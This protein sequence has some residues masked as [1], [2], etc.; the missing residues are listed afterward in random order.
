MK[1]IQY[2]HI[3]EFD[4]Y[5]ERVGA[6]GGIHVAVSQDG[7]CAQT[8]CAART[9]AGH[10]HNDIR[11]PNFGLV[12][13]RINRVRNDDGTL[14]STMWHELAHLLAPNTWHT[15]RWKAV[16]VE[17]GQPLGQFPRPRRKPNHYYRVYCWDLVEKCGRGDYLVC[18]QAGTVA[19]YCE[20]INGGR[21]FFYVEREWG[22]SRWERAA[23]RRV[24][25]VF[26]SVLDNQH[27]CS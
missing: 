1:G 20:A 5:E 23:A 19:I 7:T 10:A 18:E 27:G 21:L 2:V 24:A 26:K 22:L 3:P 6:P 14:S 17:L 12:C 8:G 16:M 11:A 15:A 25:W 9:R 4:A 13:V